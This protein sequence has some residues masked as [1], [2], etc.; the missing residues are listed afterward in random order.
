[1]HCI[2][3]P[4]TETFAKAKAAARKALEIDDRSANAQAILVYVQLVSDWNWQGSYDAALRAI[5]LS[6]NLAGGHYVYS[7]WYLTQGLFEEA[8]SEARLA[9]SL[10][11]LSAKLSLLF[12]PHSLFRPA[13]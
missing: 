3:G 1:M 11:P 4:A 5:E 13:L 8:L 9:L 6:P 12:R 7:Y 10:D 2:R